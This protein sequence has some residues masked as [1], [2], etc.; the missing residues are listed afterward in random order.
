MSEKTTISQLIL[1]GVDWEI[2]SRLTRIE[3][4]FENI[5]NSSLDHAD[6]GEDAL[7]RLIMTKKTISAANRHL[8]SL[9][10]KSQSEI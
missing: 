7:C 3:T 10:L 9:W 1:E 2:L 6:E 5:L 4:K 8:Y